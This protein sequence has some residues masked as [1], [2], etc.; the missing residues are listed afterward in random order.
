M[1]DDSFKICVPTTTD[2][3]QCTWDHKYIHIYIQIRDWEV[4]SERATT[5][6]G[7]RRISDFIGSM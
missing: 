1:E 2:R 5:I 3:V 4:P 6:P 7:P